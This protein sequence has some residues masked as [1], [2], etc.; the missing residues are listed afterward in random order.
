MIL[1]ADANILIDLHSVSA[2]SKLASI[3]EI[4]VL[5]SVLEECHRGDATCS[6]VAASFFR[7]VA[8]PLDCHEILKA[9]S[10][11]TDGL[12]LQDSHCLSYA[13]MHS[14][15]L[16]T[17]DRLLREAAEIMSVKMHG[18][19]WIID[20]LRASRAVTDSEVC[21]WLERWRRGRRRLPSNEIAR[22]SRECSCK[23]RA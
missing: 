22:L 16:L 3:G 12:S 9:Y 1:L 15:T 21:Q 7:I 5:E 13:H 10:V 11:K 19:I 6:A 20:E 14:R 8:A 2:L 23:N 4:E 17:G 18:T